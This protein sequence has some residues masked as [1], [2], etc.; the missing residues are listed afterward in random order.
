MLV[1]TYHH[2]TIKP[3]QQRHCTDL[4]L[5]GSSREF[6]GWES[7]PDAAITDAIMARASCFLPHL[8]GISADQLMATTRVGLRPF[9][10]GGLPAVGLVPGLPGVAVAAGHEGS[11]LCLGPA[12]AELVLHQ[13]L[14]LELAAA[15]A[16]GGVSAG[17]LLVGAKELL[18]ETRLAGTAAASR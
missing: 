3:Y 6:S 15:A 14:G 16:D 9:A 10:V 5:A 17:E 8:A 4:L 11:G 12:T 18:P 7:V 2:V 13:L 1:L